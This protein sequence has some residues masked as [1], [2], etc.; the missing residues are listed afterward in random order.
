MAYLFTTIARKGSKAGM[1]PNADKA[2]REWFRTTA[3]TIVQAAPK[4][5]MGD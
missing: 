3:A 1:Q 2:A 4:R 5:L